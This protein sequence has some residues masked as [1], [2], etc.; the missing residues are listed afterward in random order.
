MMEVPVVEG[1]EALWLGEAVG[2][3]NRTI[4]GSGRPSSSTTE[5]ITART[6]EMIQNDQW[7]TLLEIS[8]DLGLSY[9]NVQHI[10]SDVLR[11][12]KTVL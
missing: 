11:Y 1:V 5:I 9:S 3:R 6:G 12:S 7:V 8:S 4:P 2:C 10:V